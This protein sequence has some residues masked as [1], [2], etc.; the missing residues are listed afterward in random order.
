M[1][2]LKDTAKKITGSPFFTFS[3]PP[4]EFIEKAKLFKII[5]TL[6]CVVMAIITLIHPFLILARVISSGYFN[7]GVKYILAFVFTWLAV[8]AAC[9]LGFHLWLDRRKKSEEFGSSEFIAIPFFAE[10]LKTFGEWL[11][12]LYGVIGAV[13]GLFTLIFLGKYSGSTLSAILLGVNNNGL[14]ILGGL[15]GKISGITNLIF[16]GAV[17]LGPVFG[18]IIIFVTRFFA[19]RLKVLVAIANNTKR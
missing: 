5:F 13:G 14:P 12:L 6:V 2:G 15:G 17:I 3:R 16:T 1:S 7:F 4:L 19:E 11:G 9:W 18:I 10:L 8:L